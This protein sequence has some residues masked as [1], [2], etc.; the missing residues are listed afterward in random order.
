MKIEV[1]IVDSMEKTAEDNNN[2]PHQANRAK[3]NNNNPYQTQSVKYNNNTPWEPINHQIQQQHLTTAN[4]TSN[5]TTNKQIRS[6]YVRT[7]S[8]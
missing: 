4:I 1:A 8:R 3:Y 6:S 5:T 7:K 2:N